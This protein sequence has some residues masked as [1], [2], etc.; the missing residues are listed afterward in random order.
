MS[1][2]S[3]VISGSSDSSGSAAEV[4]AR[5]ERAAEM[6]VEQVRFDADG[7]RQ[8]QQAACRGAQRAGMVGMDG[9]G[10]QGHAGGAGGLGDARQGAE[11][12]G[13]LQPLDV[14]VGPSGMRP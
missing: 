7:D 6:A 14:E 12:A 9:A 3:A 4:A 1:G 10:R 5:T 2:M 13:G 8:A 11:G